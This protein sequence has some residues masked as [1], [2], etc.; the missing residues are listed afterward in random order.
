MIKRSFDLDLLLRATNLPEIH[1]NQEDFRTWFDM[2][3]NLMFTEGE[4]VGL[5]TYEYP[6]VYTVHWYYK[7]RGREAI[8]LGKRMLKNLFDNYGAETVRGVVRTDLKA[9]RWAARQVGYKSV[10]IF[11]F[12]DGSENEIFILTKQELLD[13]MKDNNHG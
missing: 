11:K 3:K 9:S 7:V 1:S 10:G 13:K 6:G 5:A 8:E 4:N 12:P 2:P